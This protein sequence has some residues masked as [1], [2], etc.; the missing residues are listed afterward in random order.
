M[1]SYDCA[2]I[3][4]ARGGS[5]G[6]PGK[7][8]QVLGK[9]PLV[10]RAVRIA[11]ESGGFNRVIV[12][13][14]DHIILKAIESVGGETHLRSKVTSTDTATSEE[15]V[16]EVLSDCK[17]T[18]E[19]CF[20]R[21]CSTPFVS[22]RDLINILELSNRHPLDSVVSGYLESVH[23]WVYS[24]NDEYVTPIGDSSL[25]RVPR[26]SK[27]SR[28]FVENGGGYCFPREEFETTKNRFIGE[29]VPYLMDKWDSID[30]DVQKDLDIARLLHATT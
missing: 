11:L 21:Q 23:H 8:L 20:L 6:I 5:K 29:V 26:Q 12:S 13:S 22:K 9:E 1:A 25:V 30:I 16:L 24:E 27:V 18:T 2:M 17:V 10:T 3:V 19:K 7:N 28:I 15:S 4:L 14:D